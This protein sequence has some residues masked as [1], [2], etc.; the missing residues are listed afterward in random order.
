MD[1][2]LLQALG[3]VGRHLLQHV[4]GQVEPLQLGERA[5][6]FRVDGG[7]LVVHEDESLY[8]QIPVNL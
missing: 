5:E 8:G 4:L 2:K 7:D 3:H 6:S 1:A